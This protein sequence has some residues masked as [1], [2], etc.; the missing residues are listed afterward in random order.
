VIAAI[1]ARKS[2]EQRGVD[3]EAKSVARQIENAQ[4]FAAARGWTLDPRF[5]FADDAVS[6][7]E[8][9]K[10]KGRQRLMEMIAAGPPFQV[11][12]MREQSRFSRRDGDEAF[13]ELKRI[14]Q[15]GIE[16]WFYQDQSRFAFGTF[17]E[18]V[19]SFVKAEAAA[20]YRRQIAQWTYEAMTRKARAGHVTGGRVFGYDNERVNGFVERRVNELEA[21]VVQRIFV[22]SASGL[23]Y[24]TIAKLLN[25][26]AALSPRSQQGRPRG[27]APSS[28]RAVLL[29]PL[30]RG[31]VVWNKT[32]KRNEKGEQRQ[33]RRPEGEW[34]RTEAPTLR[35]VT[36]E[37]WTAATQQR[38]AKQAR[39]LKSKTGR[40][41][42]AGGKGWKH[43][44]AGLARCESCG[45]SIEGRSRSHGK[46]RVSFYGC[47]TYQ[48]KGKKVCSNRLT[49]RADVV[50]A[51]ILQSVERQILDD[52]VVEQALAF[53]AEELELRRAGG[54][55]GRIKEELAGVEMELKRLAEGIASGGNF[56]SLLNAV[57]V[58]EE[59]RERLR[60]Q[61]AAGGGGQKGLDPVTMEVKLRSRLGDVRGLLRRQRDQ[62]REAL[63]ML[64]EGRLT[65][66]PRKGA[67]YEITG[68]GTL[69]P[70][71]RGLV[72]QNVASPTGFEP[73]FWP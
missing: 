25:D 7:A 23:G 45:G 21:E 41:P 24:P 3:D 57:K 47:S 31:E 28:V 34:L 44:L 29:R 27:W 50:E 39:Y 60:Q 40:H 64:I 48:R 5:V 14:A 8:V 52:G 46:Q 55:E 65:F 38:T 17:G 19:V 16:I 18:N 13:G 12:L 4:S 71:L 22:L 43:L 67:I 59:E 1:Y 69:E 70:L 73:V 61:L 11:L 56:P 26:E 53:V 30:Y 6:G 66:G 36:D 32:K 63:Q 37:E 42:A 33:R 9:R 62:A 72:P 49:V 58:R 2:T 10:L 51:M 20:D 35:I 15:A 54:R 68:T